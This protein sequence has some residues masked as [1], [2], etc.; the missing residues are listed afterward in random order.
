[1][2]KFNDISTTNNATLQNILTRKRDG[3]SQS[4]TPIVV[5]M[6]KNLIFLLHLSLVLLNQSLLDIVRHEFI[7]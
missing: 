5:S 4:T 3:R 2:R 1:M 7:A 6:K